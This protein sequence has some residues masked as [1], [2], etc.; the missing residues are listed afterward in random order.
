MRSA[1]WPTAPELAEHPELAVL[2][3]LDAALDLTVS[4]LLAL[5]P[6]LADPERPYWIDAPCAARDRAATLA[7]R[8]HSL[9]EALAG[10]RRILPPATDDLPEPSRPDDD[11]SG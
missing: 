11:L 5:Y 2:A 3:L 7:S 4:A 1:P 6:E 9:R 10:Y 8:A